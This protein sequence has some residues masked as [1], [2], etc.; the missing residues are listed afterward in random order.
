MYELEDVQDIAVKLTGIKASYTVPA[1]TLENADEVVL[2]DV[3]PETMLE[4]AQGGLLG[5]AAYGR[6]VIWPCFGS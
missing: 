6:R 3:T 5:V 4:R 1:D 2:I